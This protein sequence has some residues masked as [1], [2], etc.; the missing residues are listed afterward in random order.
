MRAWG[1]QLESFLKDHLANRF[2]AFAAGAVATAIL[3][4]GT[5]MVLIVAGIAASG[6]VGT[7]IGLAILL[8]ADYWKGLIDWMRKEMAGRAF[9]NPE[10]IDIVQIVNEPD[11]VVEILAREQETYLRNFHNNHMPFIGTAASQE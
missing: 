10:D 3:G 4:S 7:A 1:D 2:S 6:A 9:V 5:A 11:E 8:G